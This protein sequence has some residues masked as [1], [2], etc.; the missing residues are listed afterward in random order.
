MDFLIIWFTYDYMGYLMYHGAFIIWFDHFLDSGAEICQI[1]RWFFG[2]FWKIKRTLWNQLTFCSPNTD[3]HARILKR[4][5]HLNPTSFTDNWQSW[6][7]ACCTDWTSG[8]PIWRQR[9]K[10]SSTTFITWKDYKKIT[11]VFS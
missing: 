2:K 5:S 3:N 6:C 7:R 1:F 4:N 8:R 10:T 9:G 11:F